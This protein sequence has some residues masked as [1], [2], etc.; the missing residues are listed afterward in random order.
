MLCFVLFQMLLAPVHLQQA[1]CV[2]EK[3]NG[4]KSVC[5]GFFPAYLPSKLDR[6]STAAHSDGH[7]AAP[8]ID[9]EA[10]QQVT[11]QRGS[12]RKQ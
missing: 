10:K 12:R 7:C 2:R 11:P 4:R 6:C 9:V 3:K 8:S 5:G 1:F